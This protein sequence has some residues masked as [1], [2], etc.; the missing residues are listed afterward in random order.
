MTMCTKQETAQVLE[1][2]FFKKDGLRDS[3]IKDIKKTLHADFTKWLVGGGLV[4]ILGATAAWFSLYFQVQSN[5]HELENGFTKSE[6][7]VIKAQNIELKED[8]TDLKDAFIRLDDRLRA[9]GI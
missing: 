7:A 4:I 2:E 5:T 8:I 3:L 1:H 6:A 9:K